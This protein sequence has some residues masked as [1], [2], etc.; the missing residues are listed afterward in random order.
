MLQKIR[1]QNV[2]FKRVSYYLHNQEETGNKTISSNVFFTKIK[3]SIM[4]QPLWRT[5][6]TMDLTSPA[7]TRV[8]DSPTTTTPTPPT[9]TA[10][11]PVLTLPTPT[12]PL[13]TL[14]PP[15]PP[16]PSQLPLTPLPSSL[17][18]PPPSST[19]TP[20]P[21]VATWPTTTAATSPAST[22]PSTSCKD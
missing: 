17:P 21:T 15:T 9:T 6:R 11:L 8:P 22:D 3:M 5:L 12:P 1:T 10:T 4:F 19:L 14:P 16:P 20:P 13:P 18:T 2:S 7:S